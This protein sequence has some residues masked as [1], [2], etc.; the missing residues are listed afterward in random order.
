MTKPQKLSKSKGHKQGV[1]QRNIDSED[2]DLKGG[3]ECASSYTYRASGKHGTGG[4]QPC[5]QL[6][7]RARTVV[8]EGQSQGQGAAMCAHGTAECTCGNTLL[9]SFWDIFYKHVLD[10]LEL[11]YVRG[12]SLFQGNSSVPHG[13]VKE[14]AFTR[15]LLTKT[16]SPLFHS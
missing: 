10:T 3:T 11:W 12:G 16:P 2:L 15:S 9:K 1:S 5:M 14:P 8:L 7:M 4:A 13:R 6:S